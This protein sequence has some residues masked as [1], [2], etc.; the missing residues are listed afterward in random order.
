[1]IHNFE[2]P[3]VAWYPVKN[4]QQLKQKYLPLIT[5]HRDVIKENPISYENQAHTSYYERYSDWNPLKQKD[6]IDAIVWNPFDTLIQEKQ[7]ATP[8]VKS[9]L[10]DIWWNYYYPNGFAKPHKHCESHF[11]GVYLLKL[12]EINTT[13]FCSISDEG[14]PDMMQTQFKTTQITEGHV[15]IFPSRLLHYTIPCKKNRVIIA[16]NI[17]SDTPK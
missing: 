14:P 10:A 16:W 17:I 8:P 11:S 7:F 4:H 6:L 2:S 9:N 1:M 5:E 12:D 15:V 3:F 13:E